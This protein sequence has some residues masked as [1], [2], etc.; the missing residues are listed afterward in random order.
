[1]HITKYN[2]I[3]IK[4]WKLYLLNSIPWCYLSIANSSWCHKKVNIHAASPL[5]SAECKL[6]AL[7]K[8]FFENLEAALVQISWEWWQLIRLFHYEPVFVF[9]A[10][11]WTFCVISVFM[12]NWIMFLYGILIMWFV[13]T[14]KIWLTYFIMVF[15]FIFWCS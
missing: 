1:M 13:L 12:T 6:P 10:K 5:L 15:S 4:E 9:L 7:G 8:T 2:I 3:T 14:H 11:F